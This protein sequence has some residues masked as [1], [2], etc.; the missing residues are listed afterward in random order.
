MN[1]DYYY[2]NESEQFVFYRIPKMLFKDKLFKDV[3]IDAKVLYGLM[4]DRMG[5]S[6]RNRWFDKEN[7]VYI[8]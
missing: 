6:I 4:L 5:L 8:L 7:R 2:G 3:S 1:F